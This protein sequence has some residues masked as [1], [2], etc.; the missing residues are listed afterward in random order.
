MRLAVIPARGG[1]R[2]IPRKN[3][4]PFCGRPMLAWTIG[5]AVASRL[6]DRV[7]VSTEDDEVR[8]VAEQFGAECPFVRPAEL[9]DDHATTNAVMAHA[10]RWAAAAGLDAEAICCL[11]P[12]APFLRAN[13]LA[14]GLLCLNDGAWSYAFA[15]ADFSAPIFRAFHPRDDGGVEMFFP[16]HFATRSQDLPRALY[17]AGLFYWGRPAAW[18]EERM[19]FAPHSIPIVLP[20]WRVHDI[21]DEADWVRAERL[22]ACLREYGDE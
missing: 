7:I 17:D 18:L 12:T 6:F 11:Y 8:A 5:T 21:D 3:I 14:R 15:A 16:E 9:A 1:S 10:A 13:D 2:R 22:F 20:R 4:R 19:I